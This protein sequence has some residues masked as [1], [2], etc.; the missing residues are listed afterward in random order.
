MFHLIIVDGA[1]LTVEPLVTNLRG[2]GV[3]DFLKL[4][5]VP[6]LQIV[7]VYLRINSLG[8]YRS[9]CLIGI[10]RS[11]HLSTHRILFSK[12]LFANLGYSSHDLLVN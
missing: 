10:I 3:H 5:N 2:C 8:S 12:R 4:W 7:R 1:Y 11:V 9:G 6:L